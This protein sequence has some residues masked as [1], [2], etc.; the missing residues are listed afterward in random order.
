MFFQ[1]SKIKNVDHILK[2][3]QRAHASSIRSSSLLANNFLKISDEVKFSKKPIVAL[4]STIITHG[5]PYPDNLETALQVESEVR[6][7][8]AIPGI[9]KI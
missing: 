8:G 5:L 2:L 7:N 9:S 6:E 3:S 4:E 1:L